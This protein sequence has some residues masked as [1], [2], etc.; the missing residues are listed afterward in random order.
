[1][2]IKHVTEKKHLN[3]ALAS[4]SV[5][6]IVT[7]RCLT[8]GELLQLLFICFSWCC[9]SYRVVPSSLFFN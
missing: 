1:M 3:F 2:N 6:V 4:A 9:S 7:L 5:D 8:G